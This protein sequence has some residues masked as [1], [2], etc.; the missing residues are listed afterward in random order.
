MAQ[1]GASTGTPLGKAEGKAS[2]T[3]NIKGGRFIEEIVETTEGI[4]IDKH[5]LPPGKAANL[6]EMT[7]MAVGKVLLAIKTKK[8]PL[9]R[10]PATKIL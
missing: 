2:R 5:Q 7:K 10:L 6:K 3:G 9:A 1:I 4:R 8:I